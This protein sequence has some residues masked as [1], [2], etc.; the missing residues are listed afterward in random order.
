ML[1]SVSCADSE[2]QNHDAKFSASGIDKYAHMQA[3]S[4]LNRTS[5]HTQEASTLETMRTTSFA[6]VLLV[7]TASF[8]TALPQIGYRTCEC[9]LSMQR[10]STC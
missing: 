4:I 5:Y 8:T 6:T 3:L 1:E 10:S 2:D 7:A 9:C